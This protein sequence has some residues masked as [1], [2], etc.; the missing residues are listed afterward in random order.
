MENEM[1]LTPVSTDITQ[2]IRVTLM[3]R[4]MDLW[5]VRRSFRPEIRNAVAA[6]REMRGARYVYRVKYSFAK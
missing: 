1:N 4:I 3:L 2:T 5:K 6:L